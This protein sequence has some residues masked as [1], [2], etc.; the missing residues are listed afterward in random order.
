MSLMYKK[1]RWL[2][3]NHKIVVIEPESIKSSEI[4]NKILKVNKKGVFVY[5]YKLSE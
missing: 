5:P 3:E 2:V 1:E 4:L